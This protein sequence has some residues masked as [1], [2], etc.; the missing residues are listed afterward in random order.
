MTPNMNREH[1]TRTAPTG[2]RQS[3]RAVLLIG[4][5]ALVVSGCRPVTPPPEKSCT[6]GIVGDSLTVGAELFGDLAEAFDQRDCIIAWVDAVSGRRTS[7]GVAVLEEINAAGQLPYALVIGLGTNDGTEADE[8]G[9]YIDRVMALAN[10]R[11]VAWIDVAHLPVRSTINRILAQKARQHPDLSIINWNEPYW[12][13]P[14]WRAT[15]QIHA[16]R[17]GYVA[18]ADMMADHAQAITK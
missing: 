7:S 2:T 9:E 6:V 10:G 4:V 13:N 5:L 12:D 1:P 14:S 17:I 11:K 8:I 18:R 16:T 3:A 15:D